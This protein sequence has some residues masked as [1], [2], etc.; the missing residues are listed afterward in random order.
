MG[1]RSLYES[2]PDEEEIFR[3]IDPNSHPNLEDKAI[4]EEEVHKLSAPSYDELQ[5]QLD[6]MDHTDPR[7]DRMEQAIRGMSA[8]LAY[9]KDCLMGSG[10]SNGG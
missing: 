2:G 10:G 7:M 1:L 8:D 9:I 4:P 6:E 5:E 3:L